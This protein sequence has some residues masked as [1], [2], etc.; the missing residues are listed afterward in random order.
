MNL[1]N[2]IYWHFKKSKSWKLYEI[3]R[4][5]RKAAQNGDKIISFLFHHRRGILDLRNCQYG[6]INNDFVSSFPRQK[7]LWLNRL[8]M[9]VVTI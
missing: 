1:L 6:K 4:P 9:I 7:N 8:L 5:Q 3:L 2:D